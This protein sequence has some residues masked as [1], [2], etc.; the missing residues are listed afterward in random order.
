MIHHPDP[1]TPADSSASAASGPFELLRARFAAVPDARSTGCV[2]H[3]IDEVLIIALCS[4]LSDNAAFTDMEQFARSQMPWLRTFLPMPHG[5]PSHDV[6]RNVFMAIKPEAL[7]LIMADWCGDL[8]SH[9]IMIDGKALRGTAAATRKGMVHILRAWVHEA[10]LSAGHTVCSEKTNELTA[11]PQLLAMLELKGTLV[12]ID[13]MGTHPDI[14]AQIHEA[15]GDYLL[16][17]KANQKGALKAVI[18]HFAAQDAAAGYTAEAAVSGL[19]PGNVL[20]PG[21]LAPGHSVNLSHGRY[22]QRLCTALGNLDFF[23]KSWKWAGLKSVIRVIRTTHRGGKIGTKSGE[24]TMETHYYLSSLAPDPAILSAHIRAHWSV[25]SAHHVLDVTFGE[26]HCQ[27]RDR[28]AAHNLCILRETSSKVLRDHLPKKSI[29][30][31]RKRAA[32]D[33]EFR[34]DLLSSI[35]HNFHA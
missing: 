17:L 13:A 32:L 35:S 26:D 1:A 20:A 2:L 24:P 8:S 6:F 14:A 18:T 10:G 7:L 27:V 16:A 11:L 3:T 25:E 9:Q 22:E 21:P 34:T 19:H 23:H 15:G 12:S 31:K 4:M 28:T 30:S 33:P 5:P 29:R